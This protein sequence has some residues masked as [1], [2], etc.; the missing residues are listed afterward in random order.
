MSDPASQLR[1]VMG[2]ADLV[3]FFVIT[4]FG[5][6][7]VSTAAKA[8]PAGITFWL[9]AGVVFYLPLGVCVLALTARQ[10]GEGGLYL[11]AR[12]SF[13]EF[14]GFITGW[15]YWFANLAYLPF[16]LYFVAGTALSLGGSRWQHL[17]AEP[18]YFIHFSLAA[19]TV[20]TAVNIVGLDVGKWL[21]NIGAVGTWLPAVALTALSA[22]A[23]TRSGSVTDLSWANFVPQP[24]LRDAVVWGA[25]V[26]SLTGLEAASILGNEIRDVRRLIAPA[27]VIGATLTLATS[28]VT[29]LAILV[30]VPVEQARA[31]GSDLFMQSYAAAAAGAG[32]GGWVPL[33]AV[34]V[35]VGHL[36]KVGAWSAAGARLP[37]V[38]GLDRRLPPAFGRLHRRWGTPHVALLSQAGIIAALLVLGQAG[39]DGQGRLRRVP[40]HDVDP[41]VHPVPVPFRRG[42]EGPERRQRHP[43]SRGGRL[44]DGGRRHAAGGR[45]AGRRD[46]PGSVRNEG[47]RPGGGVGRRGRGIVPAIPGADAGSADHGANP[48]RRLTGHCS[49]SGPSPRPGKW[50]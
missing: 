50:V 40:E 39:H 43:R 29:T 38:A 48:G 33:I 9:I 24:N 7:W 35:A 41:D 2:F 15:C 27:L 42:D 26:F 44:P 30:V 11:W 12:E 21:H 20:V 8:G 49:D 19:L 34:L 45:A 5:L 46:G 37:F 16:V 6:M 10:P 25:V 22:G 18:L 31:G 36:G 32:V 4:G 47:G 14:A 28:I 17:N 23:W 13:G 3:L 1:R